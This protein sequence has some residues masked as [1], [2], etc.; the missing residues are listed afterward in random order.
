LALASMLDAC[1]SRRPCLS[2]ACPPCTCA[3]QRMFVHATRKFF[4]PP[5]GHFLAVYIVWRKS[6]I[7]CTHLAA[8]DLY[9]PTRRRL[10]RALAD[11]RV[12]AFGGFDISLNEHEARRFAPHWAPHVLIFAPTKLSGRR[13]ERLREW[14]LGDARTPRPILIKRFDGRRVGRAYALKPDFGRRISLKPRLSAD[15]SRSTFS[16]RSK[17][18][19]G[20]ERV[21]LA[22]ALDR[23]GLDSR[24]FL[25][26]YQL[27]Q[28]RGDVEIVRISPP[29]PSIRR[30]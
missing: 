17:P 8:E 7:D 13:E 21:D 24:L 19:F 11:I 27:V 18:I 16:T 20:R 25:W 5:L 14:F 30:S 15:G 1:R 22:L 12:P 28:F 4:E 26:G 6:L 23:A 3:A 9:G 10:R 2:G 29:G